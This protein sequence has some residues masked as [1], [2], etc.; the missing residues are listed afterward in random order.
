MENSIGILNLQEVDNYGCVLGAYALQHTVQKLV[1]K[2]KVELI[3]Y[4]PDEPRKSAWASLQRLVQSLRFNGVQTTCR[5]YIRK[6]RKSSRLCPVINKNNETGIRKERFNAF[7]VAY[8]QRSDIYT[9]IDRRNAPHYDV[10][11]VGSDVVW[12]LTS[13][14]KKN[15]PAFLSFTDEMNC[16]RITYAASLGSLSYEYA[17][18]KSV[19]NLYRKGLARFDMVSVR[20]EASKQYLSSLYSGKIRCC[21]D[22]TLLLQA[23]DYESLLTNTDVGD[24]IYVYML[25]VTGRLCK[26]INEISNETGLP[27]VRCC[28][29]ADG[30]ENVIIEAEQDGPCEFLSRIKNS[31]IVITNSFHGVCF[32]ILYHK[33]FFY[34][35]RVIQAYK[36]EELL[37]KIGLMERCVTQEE[38]KSRLSDPIDYTAVYERLESWRKESMDY[39]KSALRAPVLK[40]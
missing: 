21:M 30:Y 8:L 27:I 7:R 5:R 29:Q 36:T 26:T 31:S 34:I 10:Y 28:D 3:D 35:R 17:N 37:N 19:Q 40:E 23:Q 39:L 13:V 1:P 24:Y 18:R 33:P 15:P 14:M 11:I 12:I 4:R 22:S 20:E 16:R 9:R 32:S 2:S 6:I 25:N 38:L